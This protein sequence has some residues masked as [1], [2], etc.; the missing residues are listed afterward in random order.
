[1]TTEITSQLP[2]CPLPDCEGGEHH[3]HDIEV[4]TIRE[5][6]DCASSARLGYR[7]YDPHR[8]GLSE[9]IDLPEITDEMVERATSIFIGSSGY[10]APGMRAALTGFR[11]E[12]LAEGTRWQPIELAQI[13]AGMRIRATVAWGDRI[14]THT[15]VAHHTDTDGDWRTEGNRMLTGWIDPTTYEVDPATIPDPDAEL[16]EQV[17]KAIVDAAESTDEWGEDPTAETYRKLARAALTALR[18]LDEAVSGDE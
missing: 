12:L 1:M 16:I 7:C 6:H 18:A 17:A 15:G 10:A 11:A 4:Y 13:K 3:Y 2:P 8:P 9:P 14:T 5:G